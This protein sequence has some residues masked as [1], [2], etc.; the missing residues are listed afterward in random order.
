MAPYNPDRHHRR[1]IRLPHHD[2]SSPGTYFLTLCTH[3]RQPLFGTIS[4][5]TF[6]P[7]TI[8]TIVQ[9]HWLSLPRFHAHLSLDSWI[10][11]PNH[12]HG[13]LNLGDFDQNQIRK[14]VSEIIRGFKTFSARQIN[15]ARQATK[16]PVWQRDYYEHI[17]RNQ[18]DLDRIRLYITQNP[19]NWL[20]D[21]HY[22]P[23]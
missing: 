22:T 9:H 10:I 14:P 17:V 8:G 23:L 2:Y 7:N 15:R 19:L 20:Q 1:S 4:N 16:I 3:N 13:L 21:E 11:M 12:L 6:Q 18:D 5:Q